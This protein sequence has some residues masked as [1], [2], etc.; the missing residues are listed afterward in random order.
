MVLYNFL[1]FDQFID[2]VLDDASECVFVGYD[3][4]GADVVGEYGEED[5]FSEV[6]LVECIQE[7]PLYYRIDLL[8]DGWRQ[9][10]ELLDEQVP[11]VERVLLIFVE[12]L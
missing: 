12:L 1:C 9:P 3:V 6:V 11:A 2:A 5:Y 4:V 8:S 7:Y 10:G